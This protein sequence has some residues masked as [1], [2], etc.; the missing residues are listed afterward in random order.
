MKRRKI[1]ITDEDMQRLSELLKQALGRNDKDKPY[2]I[3]L[4]DV[5]KSARIVS[6][7]SVSPDIVTMQS[8]VRVKDKE[9]G[10]SDELTLVFPEQVD[11]EEGNVSVVAPLGAALLGCRV[12]DDVAFRIPKGT[13]TIEVEAIL[14]QPEA[15][16]KSDGT[17]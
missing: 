14:Y 12:G 9:D 17:G 11:A 8:R 16:G 5:L 15:A 7:G 13:R 1:H 4:R 6:P 10:Q 2:L 3:A